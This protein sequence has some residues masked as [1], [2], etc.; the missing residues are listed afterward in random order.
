[1]E[2]IQQDVIE[3]PRISLIA[4]HTKF[5]PDLLFSRIAQMYNKS[6]VFNTEELGDSVS[7]YATV[8]IADG[9]MVHDWRSVL[10]KY[11]KLPSIRS[12][13]DFLFV[14]HA[15]TKQLVAKVRDNC[16]KGVFK[17]SPIHVLRGRSLEESCILIKSVEAMPVWER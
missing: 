10:T 17:D 3:F 8:T 9:T 1:M 5:S 11:L 14:K 4:E 6:D 16:Y 13:H 7:R 12:L 2:L 15:A